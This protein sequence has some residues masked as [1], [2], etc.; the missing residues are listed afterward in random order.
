MPLI[1]HRI[2][3]VEGARRGEGP[4]V[5]RHFGPNLAS[6]RTYVFGAAA[7]IQLPRCYSLCD[8]RVR[9]MVLFVKA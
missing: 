8:H 3:K 1:R 7:D 4:S 2:L 9:R 6:W 5:L